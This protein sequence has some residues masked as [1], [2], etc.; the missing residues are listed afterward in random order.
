V[1]KA[2]PVTDLVKRLENGKR[3]TEKSVVDDSMFPHFILSTVTSLFET[4]SCIER[5][6]VSAFDSLTKS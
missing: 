5:P 2:I 1:V 6:A 4:G 3:I